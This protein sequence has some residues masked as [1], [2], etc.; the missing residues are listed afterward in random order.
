MPEISSHEDNLAIE[1]S[2]FIEECTI[3]LKLNKKQ[4]IRKQILQL[5]YLIDINNGVL[6]KNSHLDIFEL[7][8]LSKKDAENSEKLSFEIYDQRNDLDLLI[9]NFAEEYPVNQL[10]II[11]KS[12]L[13]LAF[14]EVKKVK[15][16]EKFTE[17]VEDFEN[18]GYLFGSDNS[19]KFIK[20][21]IKSL[22]KKIKKIELENKRK[23][24]NNGDN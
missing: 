5:L 11:D 24:G 23:K 8:K 14:W 2:E 3:D 20:G 7:S 22:M 15:K 13:R 21:V 1:N 19:N 9:Q 12:L 6:E 18:L 17:L 10:S 16:N 4:L